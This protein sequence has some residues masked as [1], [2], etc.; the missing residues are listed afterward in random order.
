MGNLATNSTIPE[1]S[2]D[3]S[4]TAKDL[5]GTVEAKGQINNVTSFVGSAYPSENSSSINNVKDEGA[6]MQVIT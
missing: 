6:R 4:V 5:P 3:G 2:I 1:N